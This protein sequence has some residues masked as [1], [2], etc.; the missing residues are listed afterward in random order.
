MQKNFGELKYII[1]EFA[2]DGIAANLPKNKKLLKDFVRLL[3]ENII[4]KKE[5]LVYNNIES[6]VSESDTYISEYIQENVKMVGGYTR[7][8]IDEANA[9]LSKLVTTINVE[10]PKNPLA[11][12][13]ESIHTLMVSNNSIGGIDKR[14]DAKSVIAEHIKKNVVKEPISDKILPNSLIANVY[15]KRF[16]QEYDSLSEETKKVLSSIITADNDTREGIMV[17]L[18]RECVDLVDA[19]LKE[20]NIEIRE[21]LL[22]TKDRLLR[23]KYQSDNYI[24]EVGKLLDLKNTLG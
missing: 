6:K 10:Y 13:H 14:L 3:K 15:S 20:A 8:Q 16:N 21:K 12:L 1:K 5:F 23:L 24:V 18:V 2:A 11:Q 19:N 17:D 7:G 4:L 9:L 22:S